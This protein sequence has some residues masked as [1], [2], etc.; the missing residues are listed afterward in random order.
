MFLLG[1]GDEKAE[2]AERGQTLTQH[3]LGEPHQ[4][5]RIFTKERGPHFGVH[6]TLLCFKILL[7][8]MH[9]DIFDVICYNK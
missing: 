6:S 8:M 2:C 7:S 4:H 1:G 5:D 3:Q 9:C